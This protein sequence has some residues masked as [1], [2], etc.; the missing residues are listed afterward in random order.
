M[1]VLERVMVVEDDPDILD[2]FEM[3]LGL[4]GG[5]ELTLCQDAREAL[6]CMVEHDPQLIV[7]DVMMPDL[8][9]PEALPMMRALPKGA[10]RLI[11]MMTARASMQGRAE[12]LELGADEVLFKPFEPTQLPTVLRALWDRKQNPPLTAA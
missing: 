8:S 6:A 9:G 12:Y 2:I 11:V 7:M 10:E 5:F 3:S 1:T 4:L